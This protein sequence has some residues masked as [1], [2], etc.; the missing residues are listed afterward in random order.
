M[1]YRRLSRML[2]RIKI[3]WEI[4]VEEMQRER[5]DMM[6]IENKIAKI[7]KEMEDGI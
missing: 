7:R 1:R 4:K 2:R 6:R 5:E 3:N